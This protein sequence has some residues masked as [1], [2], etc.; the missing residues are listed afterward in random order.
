MTK[1]GCEARRRAEEKGK[2]GAGAWGGRTEVGREKVRR[3]EAGRKAQRYRYST[4]NT[5]PLY[6]W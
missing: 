3:K 1:H 4:V 6:I 5:Y 2:W